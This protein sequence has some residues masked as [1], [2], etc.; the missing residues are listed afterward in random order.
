MNKLDTTGL[1]IREEQVKEQNRYITVLTA[2][3]GLVRATAY[4]ACR[5]GS[6]FCAATRLFSYARFTLLE[7]RGHYKVDSAVCIEQFFE[8]S[9]SL[10]VLSAASYFVELLLDVALAGVADTETLRL[11][12]H[13]LFALAKRGRPH[14]LVKAAFELRLAAISG[15]EPELDGCA[16]CGAPLPAEALFVPMDGCFYCP[17]CGLRVNA[18]VAL[19]PGAL[20]AMRYII[21]VDFKRLFSFSVGE[22][23]LHSLAAACEAYVAAQMDKH[24]KTLD[25]YHSLTAFL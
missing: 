3:D 10:P 16:V 25:I 18:T 20:E 15:Y 11:G 17:V 24:Y 2:E 4:G 9:Q 23:T 12:V 13:A 1:V 19:T 8:L 6:P 14:A 21:S 22:E 5:T 7:N